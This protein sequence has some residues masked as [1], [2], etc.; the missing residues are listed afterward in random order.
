MDR[1]LYSREQAVVQALLRKI[2]REAGLRQADLAARLGVQQSFI[3]RYEAGER[4][5]NILEV[6]R[7]CA[8][9]DLPL[10]EFARRLERALRVGED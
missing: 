2:R 8:A 6:R 10:E 7:I 5:L 3:S 9:V 4:I 1:G